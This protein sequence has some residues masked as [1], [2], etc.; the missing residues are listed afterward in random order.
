MIPITKPTPENIA[1]ASRMLQQGYLVAMPTETVYGLA[2]DATS[3]QAVARIYAL[4]NRPRINPLII[5]AHAVEALQHQVIWTP[6]AQALAQAFWPGPLTLVLDKKPGASLSLLA[7]AGLDTVAVRIPNHPVALDLLQALGRTLAAPS[8]NPSESISPTNAKD[9]Q[10]AFSKTTDLRMIL[11]GG[12]CSV[13]L[14]STIVDLTTQSP[15]IL[16]PGAIDAAALADILKM[17]VA[18]AHQVSSAS[19]KAPGMSLRHYAPQHPLRLNTEHVGPTEALLAFGP[20][21]LPGAAVTLNLSPTG[22]LTEAAAN[23]F[24]YLRH[25]DQETVTGI[26]AMPIPDRGIGIAINDRLQRAATS[27]KV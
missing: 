26:A 17:P 21:P 1:E 15:L 2:A 20:H 3:D 19:L 11:E 7:T 14:E 12:P 22:D 24:S 10:T 9:V 8:A 27:A 16:R 5:H 4:K 18:Y 23:L 25:L 6:Q 13:G